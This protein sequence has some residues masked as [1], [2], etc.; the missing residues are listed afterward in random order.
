MVT[1]KLSF[2][3][4]N[5]ASRVKFIFPANPSRSALIWVCISSSVMP[6][7][8][9]YSGSMLMSCMLFS[10]LKMLS[11]ENFVMPV[12][13]KTRHNVAKEGLDAAKEGLERPHVLSGINHP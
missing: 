9:A 2:S 4:A 12:K 8:A 5:K 1:V 7:M 10:S 13:Y 6:Q 3:L 11:W